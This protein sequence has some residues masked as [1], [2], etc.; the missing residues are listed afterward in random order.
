MNSLFRSIGGIT[1]LD[2][3][4]LL[5]GLL[6]PIAL[7]VRRWRGAPAVRFAPAPLIDAGVRDSWRVRL[8]VFPT[9][10]HGLGL[11]LAVVAIARPVHR[12][13]LPLSTEGI[14]IFLCLDVSSSM[15]AHDLDAKRTRLDVAKEAAARFVDGRPNDRI[16]LVVF[17]R[18][19]DVL[20]P[21]TLDH[22]ALNQI[23]ADVQRVEANGTEDMT[24]IGTAVARA[25]QVL[26][27]SA[28]KSKVVILL[29]D[30]EENVA[31]AQTP[32]EIAPLHAAQL[33]QSL[34]VRV[35]TIVAGVGSPTAGGDWLPLDTGQVKVV[36]ERTGGEFFEAR[37]AGAVANVYAH[38]D[39]LEKVELA[40]PRYRIEERFLPFLV[41]AVALLVVSRV[42][43]ATVFEVMP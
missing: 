12:D 23:V 5:L 13:P 1:L 19:P 9:A 21:L 29:T 15:A 25:A 37:D 40:E 17:A 14:D 26:R 34:G 41:A 8:L 38:I 18:Y 22:R 16:G 28:A 32:D 36:A 20:C 30:G 33:C 24:G 10:L 7:V 42:L 35:Y 3:W 4:M 27:G 11:V 39:E 31:T 43:Q 2:P 6:V